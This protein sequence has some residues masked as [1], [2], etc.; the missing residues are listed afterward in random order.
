MRNESVH[1]LVAVNTV[2]NAV[3][4]FVNI[5]VVLFLTP[6]IIQNVGDSMYGLW[7]LV[8]SIAG[9]AGM[10][11]LGIQQATIKLVAQFKGEKNDLQ[12]NGVINTALFFFILI[13][14]LLCL[15]CWYILPLFIDSFVDKS[16]LTDLKDFFYLIGLDIFVVFTGNV[17]VGVCLG[18][19][20]YHFRSI[21]D[22]S[23]ALLK[24]GGTIYVLNVGMGVTGLATVKLTLD[25]FSLVLIAI[26]CKRKHQSLKLGIRYINKKLI[27]QV[28]GYAGKVF[29][30]STII[31]IN[32][33]ANPLLISYFMSTVWTAYYAVA[34]RLVEYV[35]QLIFS[36]T[37]VFLPLFSELQANG[38]DTLIKQLYTQYSRWVLLLT[39]PIHLCIIFLGPSFIG[40][41]ISPRYELNSS[42]AVVLLACGAMVNGLQPL[43]ERFLIGTGEAGRY[44]KIISWSRLFCLL[45]TIL[46]IPIFGIIGPAISLIFAYA[47]EQVCLLVTLQKLL[48]LTF[49]E[50]VNSCY[51][52]LLFPVG[53]FAGS[54]FFLKSVIVMDSI[55]KLALVCSVS[56]TLYIPTVCFTAL[57]T[58]ERDTLT[59]MIG[60]KLKAIQIQLG[61]T[62]RSSEGGQ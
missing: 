57:S 29:S 40:L 50:L 24:L 23:S 58:R 15:T 8:L 22:C 60:A 39:V 16:L 47:I 56:F 38:Q 32:S 2:A 28:F 31:R 36:L 12:I 6:F 27:K 54:L 20:Q 62:K 48:D 1:S 51:R 52:K 46:L 21:I 25:I 44:T 30:A 35:T 37:S 11:D 7:A 53:L 4:F 43:V 13:G 3:R 26:V 5:A 33:R 55:F 17:F 59:C 9:Y 45:S 10:L 18:L 49:F 61:L 41:W 19:Q 14:S 42:T 34:N